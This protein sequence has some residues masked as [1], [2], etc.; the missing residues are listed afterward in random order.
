MKRKVIPE[1]RGAVAPIETQQQGPIGTGG[2]GPSDPPRPESLADLFLAFGWMGLN[3][4]GG[5]LPWA[6]RVLVEQRRWLTRE[7][8]L[9][10]L[11]FAQVMPGPNVC[12]LALM[13]GDRW[14][15]WRGATAALAGML[16]PP[17]AVV[18]TIALV[19]D[20]FAQIPWVQRAVSAMAAV[21][22]GL[23]LATAIKLARTQARRWRWLSFGAAAFIGV[24]VLRWPLPWVLAVVGPC[25]ICAAWF[26]GSR[27]RPQDPTG[28]R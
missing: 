15:G 21:A 24:G 7:E 19:H 10:S 5:V 16:L 13:V 3:G 4:F 18:M 27:A 23:L 25:A 20:Q 11:A 22:A 2:G 28:G 9:D 26:A 8:F 6:E 1:A 14:F 17:A 12:N